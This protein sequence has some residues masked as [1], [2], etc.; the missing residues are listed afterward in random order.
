M[1]VTDRVRTLT[2]VLSDRIRVD[3]VESLV[4]AIRHMR[5]VQDVVPEISGPAAHMIAEA[6]AKKAVLDAVYTALYPEQAKTIKK[7]VYEDKQV[8]IQ[9]SGASE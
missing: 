8:R 2:V 6:E 5:H 7:A 9:P 1:S 3:D 4:E